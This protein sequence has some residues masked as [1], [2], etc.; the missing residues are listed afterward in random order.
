VPLDA[1]EEAQF[2]RITARLRE[3]DPSFGTLDRG[4]MASLG[5]AA[6]PVV[7]IGGGLVLLPLALVTGW[8]ALGVAGYAAA[9]LGLV[10]LLDRSPGRLRRVGRSLAG[11]ATS[12]VPPAVRA[13]VAA[14]CLLLLAVLVLAPRPGSSGGD[15]AGDAPPPAAAAE[16][17]ERSLPATWRTMGRT[18]TSGE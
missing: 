5:R 8:Y 17:G 7:M 9:T 18:P 15:D 2:A 6:I 10:W 14:G 13:V 16:E 12:Q 11:D 4:T 1:H 3:E